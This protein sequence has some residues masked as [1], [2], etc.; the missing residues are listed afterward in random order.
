MASV[1]LDQP[2]LAYLVADDVTFISAVWAFSTALREEPPPT[3]SKQIQL[4]YSV[5]LVG[6]CQQ[7]ADV[8]HE[9][10]VPE[11]RRKV[12]VTLFSRYTILRQTD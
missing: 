12:S 4:P 10:R 5:V 8:G 1:A 9:L 11:F 6:R 2:A 7:R 3:V